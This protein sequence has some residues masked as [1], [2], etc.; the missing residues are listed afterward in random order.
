[1]SLKLSEVEGFPSS[2]LLLRNY[3]RICF[4]WVLALR[5]GPYSINALRVHP[6]FNPTPPLGHY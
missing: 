6:C 5:E 2:D 1:M 4:L 3:V